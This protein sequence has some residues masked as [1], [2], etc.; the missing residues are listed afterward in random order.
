MVGKEG[1]YSKALF[2][3]DIVVNDII[4]AMDLLINPNRLKATLQT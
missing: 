4:D 1:C 2:Y 3:A